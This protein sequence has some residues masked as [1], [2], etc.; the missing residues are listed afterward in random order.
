MIERVTTRFG[1]DVKQDTDIR[2]QSS[3]KC[4]EEPSV[5]I[6]FLGILFLQ[7]EDHLARYNTLFR[8]FEFQVRV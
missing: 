1:A 3:A 4:I 5:R 6:E 7:A 2:R 8:T